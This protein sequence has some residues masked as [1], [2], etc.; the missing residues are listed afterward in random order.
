MGVPYC[1]A[2][3]CIYVYMYVCMYVY[4]YHTTNTTIILLSYLVHHGEFTRIWVGHTAQH[5][6]PPFG[7]RLCM[8]LI[9]CVCMCVCV[10][11]HSFTAYTCCIRLNYLQALDDLN[12]EGGLEIQRRFVYYDHM[13]QVYDL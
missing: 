2:Y 3:V 10:N 13:R 4:Y 11:R 6:V 5:D 7:Q 8:C 12:G 9:L 1:T